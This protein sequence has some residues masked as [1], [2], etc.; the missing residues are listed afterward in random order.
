VKAI[1]ALVC[2]AFLVIATLFITSGHSS[3]TLTHTVKSI[4]AGTP[5]S[6]QITNPHGVRRVN[7]YLEQNG[8]QY[9][10]FEQTAPATRLW[11]KKDEAPRTLTF[12]AGKNK[13]PNLKEGKARL[14]VEAISNDL[15]G[16]TDSVATDVDVVLQAPRVI[17][18]DAQHY[19]NQGGMEL[20]TFTTSGS[21]SEAGVKVGPYTFR[22]FPLPGKSADQRFAMFGYPW[23]LPP[24]VTPLVYARNAAGT[25]AT[26]H[27]WFKL[28]PKKFR[29]RDF[30]I[31]DQLMEKLVNSVDPT[32]QLAPGP[33]LLSRFL[34][35]N[36]EMRRKNNQQLAD[37]RYK[38]EE[39]ILWNGPFIHW[40]KE[41]ADFAD[42]RNYIYHGKKV[43]QQVHLGFD[44]SDV[45]NGPV[46]AANDGRVVHAGD[47]GI[48]GNCVVVDHGYALQSIYG[49]MRQIDVKVGDMVKKGQKMGIAGQT[50]LAGGVHVHFSMQVDGVQTNPREWWDEHWIRDRI[51]S[52]LAP[53][54][55][56]ASRSQSTAMADPPAHH[57]AAAKRKARR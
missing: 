55:V 44:L 2:V 5:V 8:A 22:S 38:T 10:V 17:P 36:G 13:A 25:E 43:D 48:Y 7:A 14:V 35:I 21:W 16:S 27:F 33:D 32:G 51:L 50:G 18:D 15:R 12:E 3:L 47:L 41:E 29:V 30:P 37:L 28:F 54:Q 57:H 11:W 39:K 42:V 4:G 6:V 31:D 24:D 23:D 40:G 45:Q 1:I 56:T 53:D 46:Q 20:V 49:H 26:A 9:A 19:I 34:K 52:K